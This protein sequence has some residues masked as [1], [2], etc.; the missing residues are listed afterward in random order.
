MAQAQP[1]ML[2]GL[3]G[4]IG[5]G[6]STIAAELARR[7]YPVYYSDAEAKR[8]IVSNPAVRSQI[9]YL[10]GSQVFQGDLYQT[11]LVAEQ[12]FRQPE[13]LHKLNAIVHPAVCF[14]VRHWAKRQAENGIALCF[15]ESAILFESGLADECQ[16]TVAVTAPLETRIVR[17]MQRDNAP[18]EQVERRILS[19]MSDD[20]RRRLST[21][22]ICNDG[23][24]P[25]PSLVT[26]LLSTINNVNN[27]R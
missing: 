10:F 9:E 18:R 21:H 25:I 8:I 24:T 26:S 19:Q 14:D 1:T 16:L 12:V 22:V 5:S 23:H 3:T 11:R 15:V 13:L 2:I 27:L 17:T 7:G 6:K 4:G 20:Q